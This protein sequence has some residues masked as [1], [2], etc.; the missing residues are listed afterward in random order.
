[1]QKPLGLSKRE[2]FQPSIQDLSCVV[3]PGNPPSAGGAAWQV[4]PPPNHAEVPNTCSHSDGRNLLRSP[5]CP[6]PFLL[7][8]SRPTKACPC[9]PLIITEPCRTRSSPRLLPEVSPRGTPSSA[10]S[11]HSTLMPALSTLSAPSP[12]R[13][14]GL[15]LLPEPSESRPSRPPRPPSQWAASWSTALL[16][17][18]RPE[19]SSPE[20]PSGSGRAAL[21]PP[22]GFGDGT[23]H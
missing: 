4:R 17:G 23:L 15:P 12:S 8:A 20:R 7:L 10:P 14:T 9:G 19:A 16:S 2:A 3:R 11:H 21:R 1:M 6:R 13:P 5:R 22:G 18:A